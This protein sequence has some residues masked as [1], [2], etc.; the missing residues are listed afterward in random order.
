MIY[1][2]VTAHTLRYAVTST[3]DPLI[4]NAVAYRLCRGQTL[5]QI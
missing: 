1:N 2:V 3:F 5:Y 4:L